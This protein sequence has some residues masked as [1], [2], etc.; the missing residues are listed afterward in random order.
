MSSHKRETRVNNINRLSRQLSNLGATH[1]RLVA[2]LMYLQ[3]T[4]GLSDEAVVARW[5]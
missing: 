2:G 5:I 1:P 3:H 4:Y